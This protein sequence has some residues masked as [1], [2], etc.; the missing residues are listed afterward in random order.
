MKKRTFETSL[1]QAIPAGWTP[2]GFA[3]KE[4]AKDLST[5]PGEQNTNIVYLVS[6]GVATCDD[7]PVGA[8][9]ALYDSDITPIINVIGFNVDTDGQRQLKEV[10]K[11]VNGSYQNVQ[12]KE[13]LLQELEQANEV[14]KKWV[15]WKKN[16]ES[17]L[18]GDQISNGLEIFMYDAKEY[19]KIVDERQQIGFGLQYLYQTKKRMSR[20]SHDYLRARNTEYH[21]WIQSEYDELKKELKDMND[22]QF[23]EA[24]QALEDKYLQN[25]PE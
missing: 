5:F 19:R 21:D 3:L 10:A 9:K 8:A 18:K 6:D 11:A 22:M 12:D 2:T 1:N 24:I 20:E 14:A 17:R 13:T 7:D 25:A 15:D 4:A 23:N 16:K